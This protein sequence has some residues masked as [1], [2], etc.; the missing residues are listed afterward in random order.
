MAQIQINLNSLK[1]KYVSS[2]ALFKLTNKQFWQSIGEPIYA[3]IFSILMLAIFG[4]ISG[5]TFSNEAELEAFKASVIGVISM[6]ILSVG[7]MTLPSVIMEFKTSVLLKR[8]G[9][10]A[11]TPILF[12]FTISFYYFLVLISQ[13]F[14]MLL[15]VALL[16][17][18]NTIAGTGELWVNV[19]FREIN[20]IGFIFSIFYTLI[21]TLAFASLIISVSKTTVGVNIIGSIVFFSCMFLSGQL[22]PMIQIVQNKVLNGFSYLTPFRYTTGLTLMSWVGAN[23][24]VINGDFTQPLFPGGPELP[25]YSVVDQYLNWI[26][27]LIMILITTLVSLKLF[28]WNAR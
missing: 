26:V 19:I 12:L 2:K 28:K 25:V 9:A 20:W 14:W 3:Y 23:P 16:F 1:M 13:V 11:V 15:W 4:G 27:P 21:T 17:G 7:I 10:T 22:L 24:F 6:Q 5:G 8:I 18:F